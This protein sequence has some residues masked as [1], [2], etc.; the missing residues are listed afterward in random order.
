M[1]K[2]T[3]KVRMVYDASAK[4]EEN[5]SLNECLEAGPSLTP[6]LFEILLRFRAHNVV[7]NADIE[8]AFLQI[9]LK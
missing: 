6:K 3:T 4:T 2:E 8:K 9:E 1:N 5:I 7:V